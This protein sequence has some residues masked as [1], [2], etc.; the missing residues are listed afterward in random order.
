MFTT[1]S[2]RFAQVAMG[3][4]AMLYVT[5]C[6]NAGN[7]EIP[8]EE[9]RFHLYD[10]NEYPL[11]KV[12]CDPF[13]G[14]GNTSPKQGIKAELFYRSAGQPRY[15]KAQD[16]VAHT[17]KSPQDLFF[18]DINVPTRMFNTGFSTQTS[19]V[20]KDDSGNTLI[21]FFGLQ[22]RT[23]IRLSQDDEEGIYEFA[24]LSDDGSIM[25]I[26][27]GSNWSE[28]ISNDGDH[29]TRLGCSTTEIEMKRD[30][31]LETEILYYQGPRF[32]ISNL[33]LWR[34]L[35]PNNPVAGQDAR[36]GLTGNHTWFNPDKNS[37]PTNEWNNL[38]KR[39][40]K[41]VHSSNFYL[42]EEVGEGTYNPC[43]PGTAPVITNF[44][45]TEMTSDSVFVAWQT[46]IPATA[47]AL[48][49]EV[50]TGEARLTATDNILRTAHRLQVSG[51]K[52]ATRYTIQAVSV[53][54][55]LG[56]AISMPSTE[57]QTP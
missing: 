18:A 28:V 35:D 50:G 46:D 57:F 20:L 21:E 19:G 4:L 53:S 42:P 36:C 32:H 56:K 45:I 6:E 37:Q 11:N 15:Y 26:K 10:I 38:L 2:S 39:G 40:W 31:K 8:K 24:L 3:V 29:P 33:L 27:N 5:G 47:Q 9:T 22:M 44:R 49:V 51:L 7:A 34:K 12:V 30:T 1:K 17:T 16:Y 43:T 13:G 14:G 48:I 41:V 54:E 25:R 52:P 23:S 55:D